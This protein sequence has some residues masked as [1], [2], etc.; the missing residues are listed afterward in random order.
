MEVLLNFV[1][2]SAVVEREDL[3]SGI[4]PANT[5]GIVSFKIAYLTRNNLMETTQPIKHTSLDIY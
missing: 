5:R 4:N 2:C 1:A 3:K